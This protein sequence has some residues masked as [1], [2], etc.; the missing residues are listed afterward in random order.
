LA[1]AAGVLGSATWLQLGRRGDRSCG[2]IGI[3]ML[4]TGG[5]LVAV[6]RRREHLDPAAQ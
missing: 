5:G 1:L 2:G 4:A 3:A 6:R